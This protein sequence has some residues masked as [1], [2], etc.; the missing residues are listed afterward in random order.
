MAIIVCLCPLN[1]R[2]IHIVEREEKVLCFAVRHVDVDVGH[3]AVRNTGE[4]SQGTYCCV[5]DWITLRS[6]QQRETKLSFHPWL[7]TQEKFYFEGSNGHGIFYII[8]LN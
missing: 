7:T 3:E 2:Y 1:H 5:E 4:S 6:L 8:K